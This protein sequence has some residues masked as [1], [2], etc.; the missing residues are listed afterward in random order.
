MR[1]LLRYAFL[2]LAA[3][4]CSSYEPPKPAELP[5]LDHDPEVKAAWFTATSGADKFV[6]TVAVAGDS[7]YTAARDGTVT[8]FTITNG[9]TSWSEPSLRRLS[10]GAGSDGLTVAVANEQGEVMALDA[11]NG[12]ERWKANVSSE[13]LAAPA[14]GGGVVVVRSIDN[15][16]FAFGADDGKRRWTYQRPPASLIIRTPSG[17]VIDGDTAYVAFAAGKLVALALANGAVRWEATVA[18]PKGAT[19]LERVTDVVGMP[20]VQGREVCAATYQGRVA[21]YEAANGRQIWAREVSSLTGVALDAR[22]A[23]VADERGTLLAFDRTDGRS[24]WKQD[25]LS[26]RELSLP[27]PFGE[28]VAVGDFEGYVHFLSRETGAFVARYST[29]G[30]PVR[31]APRAVANAV[32]VQ[33]QDGSIQALIP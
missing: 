10:A 26:N 13:V 14:V 20:V 8:R 27:C 9:L 30:G 3:A 6:F 22:Y 5:K 32:I 11:K 31:A 2:L 18:L 4:A 24:I 33:T 16:V 15:R 21:C 12:A 23:F 28:L 25:K 29:R 19:E 1:H 17:V 7:V